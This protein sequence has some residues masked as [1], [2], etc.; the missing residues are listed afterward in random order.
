MREAGGGDHLSVGVAMPDG[1]QSMPISAP[2]LLYKR[3]VELD[4]PRSMDLA[5]CAAQG[6]QCDFSSGAGSILLGWDAIPAVHTVATDG[7]RCH[8]FGS[9]VGGDQYVHVATD[10]IC[11]G[12]SAGEREESAPGHSAAT[13]QTRMCGR[14]Q[15]ECNERGVHLCHGQTR[16]A[17][18]R[19]VRHDGRRRGCR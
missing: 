1:S 8:A 19:D 12:L 11:S 9:G 18:V 5:P 16:P 4:M 13:P 14:L 10:R 17:H 6:E 3:K 7:V 2:G 15:E